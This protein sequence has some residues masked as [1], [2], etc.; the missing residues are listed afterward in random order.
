MRKLLF[1][2]V[3]TL[4]AGNTWASRIENWTCS[5]E[6][7]SVIVS[8][9]ALPAVEDVRG[10]PRV[11]FFSDEMAEEIGTRSLAY[12]STQI[13]TVTNGNQVIRFEQVGSYLGSS[14]E[15]I[16]DL[17]KYQ[18]YLEEAGTLTLNG[19]LFVNIPRK[20]QV[21]ELYNIDV[22]CKN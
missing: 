8:T 3:T 20:G 12:Y 16:V 11:I 18:N 19:K 13:K 14:F 4:T 7:K 1:V 9:P 21:A 6:D 22:V 15:L 10:N 5:S 17:S 2:I